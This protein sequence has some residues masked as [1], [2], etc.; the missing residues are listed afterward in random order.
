MNKNICV[1]FIEATGRCR[2]HK[3][4]CAYHD[5]GV[6]RTVKGR[7]EERPLVQNY[8]I[9]VGRWSPDRILRDGAPAEA[10]DA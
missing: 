1:H 9:C 7:L 2:I 6:C 4:S 10:V 8:G 5:D 3:P